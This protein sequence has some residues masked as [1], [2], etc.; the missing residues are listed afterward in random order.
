ML[1]GGAHGTKGRFQL[2]FGH[3]RVNRGQPGIFD[4]QQAAEF[5][6]R[7]GKP[8]T[9]ALHAIR[10][11]PDCRPH[12]AVTATQRIEAIVRRLRPTSNG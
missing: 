12:D 6:H 9:D 8:Q 2:S 10:Q 3:G 7:N 11:A 4:Y 5:L 1:G